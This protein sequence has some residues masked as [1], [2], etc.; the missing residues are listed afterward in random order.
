MTKESFEAFIK[1][2]QA[3]I[4]EADILKARILPL[5][6]WKFFNPKHR[7]LIKRYCEVVE[8]FEI[9]RLVENSIEK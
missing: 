8:S 6:W 3:K 4:N 2:E 7:K 9:I 1:Q 5:K